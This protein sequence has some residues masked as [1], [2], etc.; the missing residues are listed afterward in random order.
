LNKKNFNS[1]FVLA[2]L[3]FAYFIFIE[4][5]LNQQYALQIM[6]SFFIHSLA[7]RVGLNLLG[8][9]KIS[10]VLVFSFF[11][12]ISL[13]VA[14]LI[15]DFQDFQ[16]GKFNPFILE[17]YNIGFVLFYTVHFLL[18]FNSARSKEVPI[19]KK[20]I[21]INRLQFIIILIYVVQIFSKIDISG[22]NEMI[23]FYTLGVFIFGFVKKR[24]NL[25]QNSILIVLIFYETLLAITSGLIYPL[26]YLFTFLVLTMY[27]FGGISRRVIIVGTSFLSVMI[28]FSIAFNPVK[29]YYRGIDTSNFSISEK[30]DVIFDLIIDNRTTTQKIEED[31]KEGTFWRLTYPLSAFS[32]VYAKTPNSIPYW[33]GESYLNLLYKF[34]PR[35]LWKDKP[36]EDMGQ[37]FGH[38]YSILADDNLTTSMNTPILAEAYMNFGIVFVFVIFILMAIIMALLFLKN[39]VKSI[40]SQ[41]IESV[42]NDINMCVV[43]VIFLQWESNLSMMMGKILIL[44]ITTKLL[45]W[46]YFRKQLI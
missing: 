10:Y 13:A 1:L 3:I 20:D 28:L 11:N 15:V 27:V 8:K 38:R 34:I 2:N 42:L 17:I 4:D 29:M 33:E 16:L 44:L 23:L 40:Q 22:I 32:L 12:I 9:V 45:T 43:A 7:F 14:P 46:L 36:K 37:R 35:F 21:N 18:V 19:I 6:I 25:V 5:A 39:N 24:N 26:V 41:S 30:T 31:T